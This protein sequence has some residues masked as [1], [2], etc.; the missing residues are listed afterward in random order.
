MINLTTVKTKKIIKA[1]LS[2][3]FK[4]V[5]K[6]DHM[7]FRF[8]V[9]DQET[10]IFT[11]ISHGADEYDDGLINSIAKEMCLTKRQLMD[12]IDCDIGYPQYINILKNNKVL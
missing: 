6:R 9:G 7:F 1:L 8:F 10:R 11:K 4:E 12:F 2:K 5:K 3:G